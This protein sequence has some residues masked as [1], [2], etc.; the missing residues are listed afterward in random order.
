MNNLIIHADNNVGLDYLNDN[1]DYKIQLIYIDPPYNT[2]KIFNNYCDK[3]SHIEW[4][5]FMEE[6]FLKSK[7]LLDD[8]GSLMVQLNDVEVDYCKVLLDSIYGRSN[9][10]NRITIG[11]R[12]PSGV[13]SINLGVYKSAEYILWYAK[14]K[15]KVKCNPVRIKSEVSTSYNKW[16]INPEDH[17]STW[18][19]SSVKK[20]YKKLNTNDTYD[21]FVL[22]NVHRIVSFATITDTKVGKNTK[23]L[24]YVSLDNPGVVFKLDRGPSLPPV[25][26][27]DGKQL[28]FYANNVRTLEGTPQFTK[29]LTDIW[30]D[31]SWEGIAREGGVTFKSGKKPEKLIQRCIELTTSPGDVVLDYFAGSGTTCAVAHKLS[32][33]WVGIEM[34][35][36][37]YT[38]IKPRI[39]RVL[40]GEDQTGISKVVNWT[41]GGPNF[42][43][44]TL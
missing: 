7:D 37:A 3:Y 25:F 31:I 1:V 26:I 23:D 10:V 13:S 38:H 43:F 5:T 28:L 32:R 15:S 19:F 14:D 11:A 42:K 24:K 29:A 27:I 2:G 12:A 34:G 9:F 18:M 40:S 35:E 21:D 6:R 8:S 16:I 36:Q 44:I 41:G 4:L 20:E 33:R 30:T 22:Q 39:Q 17:F